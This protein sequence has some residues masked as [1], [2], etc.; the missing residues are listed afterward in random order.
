MKSILLVVVVLLAASTVW[1][2]STHYVSPKGSD[3]NGDG[4]R[5]KPWQTV[6]H[7]INAVPDDGGEIVLQDGEYHESVSVTRAFS[8]RCIVRAEN[9]K[10]AHLISPPGRNRALSCY[11]AANIAFNG[12]E[13]SGSGGT[14]EEYLVHISEK[15]RELLFLGCLIH[16][17][18]NND[19]IKI[20]DGAH[21]V[22]FT[23]CFIF[24]QPDA[25]GDELF[26]INTVTDVSLQYCTLFE[27]Y[28]GSGRK[29]NNQGDAFIVIKNSGSPPNFARRIALRGNIFLNYLGKPDEAF[30]LLGEDG[31][32]FFEAQDITIE[33][34]LFVCNSPMRYWGAVLFK[35]GLKHIVVRANTFVGHPNVQWSGGF[36]GSCLRIGDN[37]PQEDL[38]FANNIFDDPTGNMPR[39]SMTRGDVFA[40]GHLPVMRNNLY[41][42][43][44]KPIPA[45]KTDVVIPSRDA[46]AIFADPLLPAQGQQMILPRI[47]PATGDFLSGRIDAVGEFDRLATAYAWLGA[48]SPAIAAADPSDM[49]LTDILGNQRGPHPDLGCLQHSRVK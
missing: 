19:L 12:L 43:A 23:F 41:W 21:D 44:G 18:Y 32:P 2:G 36:A 16:D 20:N 4:S 14:A 24:N 8:N 28:A 37:P 40:A 27:D 47:D 22:W 46:K 7:A 1:A 10:R 35:G 39:F 6:T 26:D 25:N 33:N 13:I 11:G 42:N 34:N 48:T 17:G 38:D 5:E 45:E 49:P 30:V 3:A 31:K 29:V 15:S 9:S